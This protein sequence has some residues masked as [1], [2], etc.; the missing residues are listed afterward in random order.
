VLT[1][2]AAAVPDPLPRPQQAPK[3][4]AFIDGSEYLESIC[5]HAAWCAG[6]V[7]GAIQLAYVDEP[8]VA[9][10]ANDNA[11]EE[12]GHDLLRRALAR[13][14]DDGAPEAESRLLSGSLPDCAR[15]LSLSADLLILGRH[16]TGSRGVGQNVPLVIHA[17]SAPVLVTPKLFLPIARAMIVDAPGRSAPGFAC[18][19]LAVPWLD[20]LALRRV[21]PEAD[22]PAD[23]PCD[24]VVVPRVAF[25]ED[26]TPALR[27]A[28]HRH[29]RSRRPVLVI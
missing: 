8:H 1:S 14:A 12:T 6:R 19:A 15:T 18:S 27:N 13:L 25:L 20:G 2:T 4:A 16:S 11:A 21:D 3:V 29:L 10:S 5:D 24:L 17:S 9:R 28:A 23:I 26:A 22:A 7:S